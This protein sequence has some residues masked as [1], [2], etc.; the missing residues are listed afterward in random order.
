MVTIVY[1]TVYTIYVQYHLLHLKTFKIASD[2]M[3][4]NSKDR[5]NKEISWLKGIKDLLVFKVFGVLLR[6]WSVIDFV[7]LRKFTIFS[8]VLG[9]PQRG[10]LGQH[11]MRG[12]SLVTVFTYCKGISLLMGVCDL[13][14]VVILRRNNDVG[15]CG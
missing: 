14:I 2:E 5:F 11:T 4:Y 9:V 1:G 7:Y 8:L 12:L 10:A 13:S 15:C 3:K 6:K